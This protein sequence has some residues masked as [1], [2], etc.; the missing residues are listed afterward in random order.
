LLVSREGRIVPLPGVRPKPVHV[1]QPQSCEI[2]VS[3][4]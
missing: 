3:R 2:E 4:A 1:A